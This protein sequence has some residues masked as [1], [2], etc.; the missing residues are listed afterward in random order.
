MF[1]QISSYE[2]VTDEYNLE[3]NPTKRFWSRAQVRHENAY[4]Q[5]RNVY[6]TDNKACFFDVLQTL[7]W[8]FE[9]KQVVH[10]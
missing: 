4:V 9:F 6:V 3:L 5:D 2:K 7:V 8:N 10:F 1:E